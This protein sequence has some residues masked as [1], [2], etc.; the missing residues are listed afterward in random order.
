M[1]Y[2]PETGV[3]TKNGKPH[4]TVNVHGY[5]VF[6]HEG[7]VVYA[8]RMAWF[9]TY[10]RWPRMID[11]INGD[12]ADNRLVNLREATS[13]MN[14]Q[15]K[16]GKR[17]GAH[18]HKPSGLWKSAIMVRGRAVHLGYYPDAEHAS[19]AYLLAKDM[20]HEGNWKCRN[21]AKQN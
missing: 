18:F 12:R 20:L 6:R 16:T 13:E 10:G 9:L 4:G 3:F 1:Q 11:H 15:N 14:A 2:D 7:K 5:V 17:A 8:H 21:Q 19:E